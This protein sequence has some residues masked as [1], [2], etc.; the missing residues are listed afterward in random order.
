MLLGA[1]EYSLRSCPTI[2]LGYISFYPLVSSLNSS[3][4]EDRVITSRNEAS[5]AIYSS[6][7]LLRSRSWQSTLMTNQS[8][9]NFLSLAHSYLPSLPP[10]LP[11]PPPIKIWLSI[12]NINL[13][14]RKIDK[15]I[16]SKL[17]N[18][19]QLWTSLRQDRLKFQSLVMKRNLVS[20]DGTY[21]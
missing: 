3:P 10:Y 5:K 14:T 16:R 12:S 2:S 13:P 1:A 4:G 21:G 20:C 18:P 11:P 9:I 17:L 15:L 8:F 19:Y 7:F 6:Y